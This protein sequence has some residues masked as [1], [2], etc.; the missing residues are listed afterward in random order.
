MQQEENY[1]SLL[2]QKNIPLYVNEVRV[3]ILFSPGVEIEVFFSCAVQEGGG[4]GVGE[5]LSRSKI[6]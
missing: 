5:D 3:F 4:G 1:P 6:I 2:V